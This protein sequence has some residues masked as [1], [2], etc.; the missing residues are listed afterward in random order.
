M[1]MRAGKLDRTITIERATVAVNDAGTAVETWATLATM[2]VQRIQ[3]LTAEELRDFGG[4]SEDSETFRGRW[5]DGVTVQDRVQFEGEPY[6]IKSLKQIGRRR[7]LE[8]TC[9]RIAAPS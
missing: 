8:I 4:S 6:N 7:S 9:K 3:N 5:L 1:T 2:R